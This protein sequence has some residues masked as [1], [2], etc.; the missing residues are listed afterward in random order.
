MP[1]QNFDCFHWTEIG[2]VFF[3]PFA[4]SL[5]RCIDVCK[6]LQPLVSIKISVVV[7]AVDSRA[8]VHFMILYCDGG[9]FCER[10][11]QHASLPA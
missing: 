10:A 6:I 8:H 3:R 11:S 9:P 2:Q 4:L 5:H 1:F 7:L